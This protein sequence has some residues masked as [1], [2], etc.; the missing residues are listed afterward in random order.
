MNFRAYHDDSCHADVSI[1]D[2]AGWD[3]REKRGGKREERM[4]LWTENRARDAEREEKRRESKCMELQFHIIQEEEQQQEE[5]EEEEEKKTKRVHDVILSVRQLRVC[6]LSLSLSLSFVCLLTHS[7]LLQSVLTGE[8]FFSFLR[9]LLPLAKGI[10]RITDR[11]VNKVR[12]R[13]RKK[14]RKKNTIN[15]F[16]IW[17]L[18]VWWLFSHTHSHTNSLWVT[19]D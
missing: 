2:V 9:F 12:E 8:F 5:E 18:V 6:S 7:F 13:E 17:L 19:N 3:S 15:F 4:F 1:A 14:E 10:D 16:S 11:T